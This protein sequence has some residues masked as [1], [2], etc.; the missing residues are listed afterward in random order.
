MLITISGTP[1]SGKTT[2]ARL[3]SRRLGVPHVYAGDLYRK[4]AERRGLSLEAFNKL[5]ERDHSIDRALD[6]KM[7]E[8][9]RQGGVVLEGRLA[10]FLALQ[11]KSDALK[12]WLTA[13]DE[14]RAERVSQREGGDKLALLHAN[15]ARQRSD[16]KRYREIYGFDLDDT[17]IYDLKLESDQQSPEALAECI[18]Q[19]ARQRFHDRVETA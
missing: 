16:A 8:Y 7:A 15:D 10:A 11:E 3:L 12:V 17:S 18:F 2:V 14:V 13:S 19:A 5:T 4:E 9:A 6:E 1:G